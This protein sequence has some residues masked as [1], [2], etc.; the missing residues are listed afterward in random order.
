MLIM[1]S[2]QIIG[3][4]VGAFNVAMFIAYPTTDTTEPLIQKAFNEA[5]ALM[6]LTPP[7]IST[8]NVLL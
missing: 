6:R 8:L 7:Q 3:A 2:A 4:A 5:K 1:G